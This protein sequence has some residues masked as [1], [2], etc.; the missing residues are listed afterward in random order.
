MVR[1][2]RYKTLVGRPDA[3]DEISRAK[4]GGILVGASVIAGACG[5][6]LLGEVDLVQCLQ[7]IA[8]GAGEI[9][10]VIGFRDLF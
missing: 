2:K 6:Y 10:L 5:R 4:V 3:I 8:L 7:T 9:L 1:K